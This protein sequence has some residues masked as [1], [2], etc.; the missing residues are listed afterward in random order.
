MSFKLFRMHLFYTSPWSCLLHFFRNCYSSTLLSSAPNPPLFFLTSFPS[1]PSPSFFVFSLPSV[2]ILLPLLFLRSSCLPLPFSFSPPSV[3]PPPLTISHH[4]LPSS[5]RKAPA[6]RT[7]FAA[8]LTAA[9][10][11]GTRCYRKIRLRIS[12]EYHLGSNRTSKG[13]RS[14]TSFV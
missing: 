10:D 13:L 7:R 2:S 9:P 1:L 8:D 11:D 3:L 4:L 14:S 6:A 5:V 12:A